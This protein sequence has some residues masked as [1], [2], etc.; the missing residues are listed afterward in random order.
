MRSINRVIAVGVIPSAPEPGVEDG[1]KVVRFALETIRRKRLPDGRYSETLETHQCLAR[2]AVREGRLATIVEKFVQ[3]G[4]VAYVD[5]RLTYDAE[6]RARIEV[7]EFV[8]LTKAS[9]G[10][11]G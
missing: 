1:S 8:N 7:G 6:G 9:R 11:E 4:T 2:D 5:G 10:R 3:P